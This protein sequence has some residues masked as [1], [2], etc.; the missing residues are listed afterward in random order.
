MM[1]R[2]TQF[3]IYFAAL[4]AARA[5]YDMALATLNAGLL[6]GEQ[7]P[8]ARRAINRGFHTAMASALSAYCSKAMVT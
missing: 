3:E 1:Q 8:S 7:I 5:S 2:P 4:G 6:R